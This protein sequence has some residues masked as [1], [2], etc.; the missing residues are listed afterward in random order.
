MLEKIVTFFAH[1]EVER[2]GKLCAFLFDCRFD[3][4][5]GVLNLM[6]IKNGEINN[7]DEVVSCSSGKT[8]TVKSV[9]IL[10]PDEHPIQKL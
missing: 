9:A 1:P 6:F 8:Y 10:R 2:N 5:R 3:R 4:Y 7:G